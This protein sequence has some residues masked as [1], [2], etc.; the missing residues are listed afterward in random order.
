MTVVIS[1]LHFEEEASDVIPGR[2]G[3][4]D[5]IFHRNL[6]PRAYRN[7]IAQMAEQVVRRKVKEFS[8]GHRRRPVR[9]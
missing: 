5:V 8:A 4:E 1:N 7:F 9:F 2:G 3:R 6:N